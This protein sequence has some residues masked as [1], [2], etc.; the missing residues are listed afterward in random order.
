MFPRVGYMFDLKNG[1]HHVEIN[2][3]YRMFL[4]FSWRIKG[5]TCFFL[6]NFLP[7]GLSSGPCI[8]TNILRSLT[9]YW[10]GLGVKI[11]VYLD[12]GAGMEGNKSLAEKCSNIV[13]STL[14]QAGFQINDGKSIWEHIQHFTWLGITVDTNGNVFYIYLTRVIKIQHAI[15]HLLSCKRTSVRKLANFTGSIISTKF[16]LGHVTQLMT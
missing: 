14:E 9:K 5:K 11:A 16:V 7:F 10:R 2:F 8:F 3:A 13:K 15:K 12:D 1:Y 4:G 6:F